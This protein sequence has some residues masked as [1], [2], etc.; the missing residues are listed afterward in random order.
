MNH[1]CGHRIVRA[2]DE[3]DE[4]ME[5]KKEHA[6]PACSPVKFKGQE[7]ESGFGIRI[8][9]IEKPNGSIVERRY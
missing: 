6:C 2:V 9:Y 3:T 7:S 5:M 1:S 4:V 8:Q